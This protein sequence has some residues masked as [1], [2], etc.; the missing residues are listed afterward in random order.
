MSKELSITGNDDSLIKF[1][2]MRINAEEDEE[3]DDSDDDYDD[4]EEDEYE[5]PVTLGFVEK[6]KF[7]WSLLRHLFPS[8]AGGTPAWL[9]PVN[10]PSGKSSLCDMCGEPLRF[11]LQAYAP[12]CD[13]ESTFHRT[14]YVF[15]CPSMAC[16]RRDQH[17][18]WKHQPEKGSRSVKVFRGQLPRDN[19]FYSSEPPKNNGSDKPLGP[20]APLCN[21][22][23][24][25]KGDKRCGNCKRA[26][27]CSQIHQANHWKSSHKIQCRAIDLTGQA[28]NSGSTN[29]SDDTPK[30][31]SNIT[32]PEY[33]IIN[34]DEPEFGGEVS[35]SGAYGKTS[36]TNNEDEGDVKS[37][38]YFTKRVARAPEQ[39]LRYSRFENSKPLW[40]ML[41][42]QPS[43]ADIPKCSSCG[44]NRS[45]EFQ[46]LPQLLYYF[47]V[48]N[49]YNSLDWGTIAVYT[50]EA[51]CDS[52]LAYKEEFAWV[53]H[54]SQST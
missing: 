39:V 15:M 26:C 5:A 8:K 12:L 42:G 9:D 6:P 16:L 2:N 38:A 52:T 31:A 41:S 54:T 3:F 44:G 1:T 20:A 36:L 19:Q 37:W 34:E 45:F 27:Y 10:L 13:K 48:K 22:C 24:T 17:E 28:S 35:D 50:C 47:D 25:W 14:L 40:P 18:Q 29:S 51:S 49:D 46:I 30:V 23:G 21:W 11:L 53:Q 43:K 7:E 32:W 4:E 33:E